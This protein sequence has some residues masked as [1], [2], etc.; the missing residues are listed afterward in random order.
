[1]RVQV[2]DGCCCGTDRKHP[3]VDHRAIR[4]AL[5]AAAILG[6]GRSRVVGCVDE[7]SQSNVVIVRLANGER[8]WLGRILG[9]D[10]VGGL[11]AWL[12]AGAPEPIPHTLAAHRFEPARNESVPVAVELRSTA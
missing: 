9:D 6:G 10:V 2:C 3:G 5:A 4:S 8:V 11:V 7:C 1:M 12:E